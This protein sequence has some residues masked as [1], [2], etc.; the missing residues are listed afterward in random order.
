MRKPKCIVIGISILLTL[1]FS[2]CGS[3]KVVTNTSEAVALESIFPKDGEEVEVFQDVN[4]IPGNLIDSELVY[5][6]T[7]TTEVLHESGFLHCISNESGYCYLFTV[8][9]AGVLIDTG[10]KEYEEKLL[11][12]IKQL[13][14]KE[15][16]L[17]CTQQ[18]ENHNGNFNR[19]LKT[20]PITTICMPLYNDQKNTTIN[21]F[22]T[23]QE[24]KISIQQAQFGKPF[25]I[26]PN[27]TTTIFYSD[28]LPK[29]NE[30][31]WIV[32]KLTYGVNSFL[33]F[34]DL[35]K[36]QLQEFTELF[37]ET[38]I[39]ASDVIVP[40]YSGTKEFP[41][42]LLNKIGNSGYVMLNTANNGNSS[43]RNFFSR[44]GFRVYRI[45]DKYDGTVIIQSD[46]K[47][48]KVSC[49]VL[50]VDQ[51]DLYE[52]ETTTAPFVDHQ[53]FFDGATIHEDVNCDQ[54]ISKNLS[55]YMYLEAEEK[56]L[57]FCSKCHTSISPTE[58][59]QE[60]E[61]QQNE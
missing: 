3:S 7:Q 26:I 21:A 52:E 10:K 38:E 19:F 31:S 59:I 49:N 39:L 44:N 51:E 50:D 15:I 27:C 56:G 24:K 22:S 14:L 41:Q 16:H 11:S 13:N 61:N 34:P 45:N 6:N 32:V 46:G 1:T 60:K 47:S 20:L 42:E 53:V 55:T 18:S 58:E 5:S 37:K 17:F 35:S 40:G 12:Y 33:F 4:G 54:I 36:Q 8:G 25:E 43:L 2:S 29:T 57:P 9:D 30:S 23:M 28:Q 48:M